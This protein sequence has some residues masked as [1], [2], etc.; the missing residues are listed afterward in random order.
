MPDPAPQMQVSP[1]PAPPKKSRRNLW[2]IIAVVVVVVV[3]ILAALVYLA[4]TAPTVKTTAVD[5]TINYNGVSSG[6][7]GA[8]TQSFTT[9]LSTSTGAQFTYTLV[10]NSSAL[11]LTHSVDS[12]TIASPYTLDSISPT[13]PVSVVAGGSTTITLTIT[14][15]SSA[16]SYVMSGT[17]NTT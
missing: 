11:V 14:V 6:Y 16:G 8:A 1:T 12:I 10:L 4:A 9:S 3:V 13:L 17:I 5:W 15:P 2:I 7:F